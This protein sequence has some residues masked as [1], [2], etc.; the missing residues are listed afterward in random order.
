MVV[1]KWTDS[2]WE[3]TYTKRVK[4]TLFVHHLSKYAYPHSR[5]TGLLMWLAMVIITASWTPYFVYV[6]P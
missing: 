5:M 4:K 3:Q 1:N 6:G 2:G